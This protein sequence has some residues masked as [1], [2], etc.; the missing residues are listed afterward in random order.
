[1]KTRTYRIDDDVISSIV[2]DALTCFAGTCWPKT[3]LTRPP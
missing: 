2:I 3:R 1:M